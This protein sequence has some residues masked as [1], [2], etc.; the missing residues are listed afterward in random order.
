VTNPPRSGVLVGQPHLRLSEGLRGWLQV[1]FGE[2]F[3]VADRPS[4]IEGAHRLQPALMVVDL[5]LAEGNL[6]SLLADLRAQAPLSPAL[7]L[8]EYDDAGLDAAALAAGAAGVVHKAAL[9]ADLPAAVD[10]VLAG[11]SFTASSARH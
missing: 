8:S 6:A 9:A 7:L 2:V 5:A 1:S 11:H 4:L 3:M 10:A